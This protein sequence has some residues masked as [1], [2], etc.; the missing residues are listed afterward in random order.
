MNLSSWITLV[1]AVKWL[2]KS[3]LSKDHHWMLAINS[4]TL[5]MHVWFLPLLIYHKTTNRNVCLP[6]TQR[7]SQVNIM[8]MIWSILFMRSLL[9]MHIQ[10][11]YALPEKLSQSRVFTVVTFCGNTLGKGKNCLWQAIFHFPMYFLTSFFY[12][13]SCQSVVDLTELPWWRVTVFSCIIRVSYC[14]NIIF[15]YRT[16]WLTDYAFMFLLS[17]VP[18]SKK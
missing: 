12:F 17:T 9:K 13:R 6:S 14:S 15:Q 4:L 2:N 5:N 8:F 16:W 18:L 3:I 11:K 1:N 7:L 10:Y